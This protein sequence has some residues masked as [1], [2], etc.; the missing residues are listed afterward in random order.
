MNKYRKKPVVIEAIKLTLHNLDDIEEFVGGDLGT[1]SNGGVMIA[2]LEGAMIASIGD[3]IIKGVKG[4]FAAQ[5]PAMFK[6]IGELLARVEELE[7][8]CKDIAYSNVQCPTCAE[9]INRAT[10]LLPKQPT[11]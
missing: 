7:D 5:A 2:T 9:I 6:M 11:E 8:G 4:E 10:E 1:N 3:Y